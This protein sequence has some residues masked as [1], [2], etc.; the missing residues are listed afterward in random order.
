MFLIATGIIVYNININVINFISIRIIS[1]VTWYL[2]YVI[3]MNNMKQLS[4]VT[5]KTNS[6][7]VECVSIQL[8]CSWPF[9]R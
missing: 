1:T 6:I 7:S 5:L 4:E 8:Q 3:Y 2:Y 9:K